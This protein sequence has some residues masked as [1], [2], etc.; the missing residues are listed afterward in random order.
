[1]SEYGEGAVKMFM[2]GW[3]WR[4]R[5]GKGRWVTEEATVRKGWGRTHKRLVR[6]P[7]T[8]PA[9]RV[10]RKEGSIAQKKQT[11]KGGWTERNITT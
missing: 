1:M 10:K 9:G 7:V 5:R 3:I 8:P 6:A 2:G 4:W 11:D